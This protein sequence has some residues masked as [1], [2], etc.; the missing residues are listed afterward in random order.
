MT[1][2]RSP[3]NEIRAVPDAIVPLYLRWGWKRCFGKALRRDIGLKLKALAIRI[4]RS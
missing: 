1:Y 2:L 4:S 3:T